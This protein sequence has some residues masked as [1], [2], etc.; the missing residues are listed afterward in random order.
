[1]SEEQPAPQE[2][3]LSEAMDESIRTT[4]REIQAREEPA[5]KEIELEPA[6]PEAAKAEDQPRRPDGTF[7]KNKGFKTPVIAGGPEKPEAVAAATE[8]A[9]EKLAEAAEEPAQAPQGIDLSRPPSSWKPAAKVAWAALPEPIRAEIYRREGDFLHGQKGMRETADFGREVRQVMEPYR[10]LIEAEGGTPTK[11]IADTM[12][13]AALFRVG[14]P[15]Q[16]LGALFQIDQQFNAGLGQFI[17]G[18]IA[19]HAG[20]VGLTTPQPQTGGQAQV[21]FADPRVDQIL[22]SLQ[23]QERERQAQA[24]R[25]TNAAVEQ[26]MTAKN[27]RGEPAYPFVDNVLPDLVGRIEALRKAN[28]AQ[29]HAETLK[30]AYEAAV[31]ANP[32]TRAVLIAAQQAQAN[33]PAETQKRVEAAKRAAA[34]N[35]PK[36][37]ALPATGPKQTLEDTIRDTGRALGMF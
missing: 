3:E 27:D 33:Q 6:K 37:G 2:R 20:Q 28:P 15:Q 9:T 24:E 4:L 12:R 10:M 19:R 11:A 31:W 30:A 1:M 13:T 29:E 32:E 21:P 25:V 17:Q 36:R 23:A 14:T 26:F 5:D 34:T 7:A 16:K 22:G 18:E 35:V 8:P